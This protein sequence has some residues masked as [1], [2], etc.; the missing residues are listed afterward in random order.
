MAI[1]SE[2]NLKK[3]LCNSILTP[4]TAIASLPPATSRSGIG[5]GNKKAGRLIAKRSAVVMRE[6]TG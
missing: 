1:V 6:I 3:A 5:T 2:K 4:V